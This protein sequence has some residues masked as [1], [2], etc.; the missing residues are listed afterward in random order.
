MDT[1]KIL[2][3]IQASSPVLWIFHH[4]SPQHLHTFFKCVLYSHITSWPT[5]TTEILISAALNCQYVS[6]MYTHALENLNLCMFFATYT[7]CGPFVWIWN[8][9]ESLGLF[10]WPPNDNQQ[11]VSS[12]IGRVIA[13]SISL[14]CFYPDAAEGQ[15]G[16]YTCS[17]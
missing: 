5:D 13:P 12:I 16:T 14:Q 11:H 15:H 2:I 17:C 7:I 8:L 4:Y 3:K 6:V 9:S 1:I 10:S